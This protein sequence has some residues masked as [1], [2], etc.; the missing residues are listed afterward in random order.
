MI[1]IY[2]YIYILHM[3]ILLI[4]AQPYAETSESEEVGADPKQP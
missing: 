4:T 2:I 1:Y 3:L